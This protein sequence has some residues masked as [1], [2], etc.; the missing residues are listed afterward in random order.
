ML[1]QPLVL[2]LSAM[3]LRQTPKTIHAAPAIGDRPI[4]V[5]DPLILHSEDRLAG[6][7]KAMGSD[8]KPSDPILPGAE[9]G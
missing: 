2:D 1:L 3:G 6:M 9:P 5:V 4:P 7:A 8:A